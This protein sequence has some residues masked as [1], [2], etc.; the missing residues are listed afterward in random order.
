[1]VWH[2]DSTRI[3]GVTPDTDGEAYAPLWSYDGITTNKTTFQSPYTHYSKYVKGHFYS[4]LNGNITQHAYGYHD[5]NI[6]LG[7]IVYW[8]YGQP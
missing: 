3:T 2:W 4:S 1:M 5:V 7:T 6:N 8:G